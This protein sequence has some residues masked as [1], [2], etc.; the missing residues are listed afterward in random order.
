MNIGIFGGAFN[1]PHIGHLIA[2]QS[3]REQL[4]LDKIF[5]VP[6][7]DP[8]HRTD[9]SRASTEH[10]LKMVRLATESNPSFEVSDIEIR[11]PGKSY[12]L[13][14]IIAF[15]VLHPG[16][17]LFL[18]LGSDN[19]AEFHTWR[20]PREI[21]ARCE[22]VV[23]MRSGFEVTDTKSAFHRAARFVS[24]PNMAIS[25][26][27]IRRRVKMGRSIRYL[28]TKEVEEYVLR[29]GLYRE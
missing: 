11:R 15:E 18:L 5:F 6:A 26:S 8:P 17:K 13:E 19:F 2:A 29:H 23:F 27:D 12:T 7:A 1:P 9:I 10:R 21:I 28:V 22:L 20:Q 24:V 16:A 14:T 3:V 25:A 4:R